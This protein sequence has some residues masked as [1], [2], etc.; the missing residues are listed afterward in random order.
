[1]LQKLLA[2]DNH[3]PAANLGDALR[4]LYRITAKVHAA[5]DSV[6]NVFFQAYR[7]PIT[8]RPLRLPWTIVTP[9]SRQWNLS[10]EIYRTGTESGP[11]VPR[12]C[13]ALLTFDDGRAI[14]HGPWS[15]SAN[16]IAVQI[17]ADLKPSLLQCD[18]EEQVKYIDSHKSSQG[19][20]QAI[21]DDILF[22]IAEVSAPRD[23]A[24][25]ME[26]I[27]KLKN[28][29]LS[30]LKNSALR[31]LANFQNLEIIIMDPNRQR[32]VS[33]ILLSSDGSERYADDDNSVPDLP[34]LEKGNERHTPIKIES[35][36]RVNHIMLYV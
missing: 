1:M 26:L 36:S 20:V 17:F 6:K 23:F 32:Y 11:S 33:N 2:E 18:A 9:S 4:H 30:Y 13:I 5:L 7:P 22:A 25:P 19:F 21:V 8:L 15:K 31:P 12:I 27:T 14:Q 10:C 35:G 24:N 29:I 28:A 3:P 34:D 16:K